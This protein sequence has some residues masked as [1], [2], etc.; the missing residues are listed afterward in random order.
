MNRIDTEEKRRKMFKDSIKYGRTYECVSCHR[1]CFENGVHLF[2]S[3]FESKLE[4]D[5][6]GLI[7]R[8]IGIKQTLKT[9]KEYNICTTCKSHLL[10]GKMPPMSNQNSLQLMDL[11]SY[12]ELH[13][14]ELENSMIALNIIFQKVF[15]LPKSR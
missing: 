14:T 12:E 3:V 7:Q 9:N 15:N 5:Y 11:T 10:K 4:K 8:S 6:P 1:V 13:L 2:T